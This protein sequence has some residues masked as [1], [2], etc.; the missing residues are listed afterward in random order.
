MPEQEQLFK[1][2]EGQIAALAQSTVSNFK[3]QAIADA[4]Q[5]LA[6]LKPD[7]IRWT[8]LLAHGQIKTNEFEWLINSDKELIKMKSL[9]NA[10]L[11]T[12]RASAFGL[13]VLNI[14][15]DTTLRKVVGNTP[16][17]SP[18]GSPV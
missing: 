15:I 18:S 1:E 17:A 13:G 14:V 9:E 6:E 8:D 10:G 16:G 11:A 7:L 3:E 4:K 2:I 12:T 5:I